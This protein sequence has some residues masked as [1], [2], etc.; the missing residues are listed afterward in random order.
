M[1]SLLTRA[2][3]S[4]MTERLS[5]DA[6][7]ASGL[8]FGGSPTFGLAMPIV[9]DGET[10]A[11]VYAD[12]F[13]EPRHERTRRR[14]CQRRSS[15]KRC[16]TTRVALL[17]RLTAELKTMAELRAYAASLLTEIEQM[18]HSD[19]D[20]GKGRRGTEE[21]AARQPRLRAEHLQ[22]PR[23]V[24]VAIRGGAARRASL[25]LVDTHQD[26]AFGRDLAVG[27]RSGRQVLGAAEAS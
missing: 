13:A 10:I 4:G 14:R 21:A 2:V 12:D 25:A 1:D 6:L 26:S 17:M 24:R 27:R 16:V 3:T 11:L 19:V 8:P 23:A 20:G 7:D 22:Q 15:P 5:G 18:Y 9:V